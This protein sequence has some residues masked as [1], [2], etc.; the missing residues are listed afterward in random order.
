MPT[1]GSGRYDDLLDPGVC[2]VHLML[3]TGCNFRCV[4]CEQQRRSPQRMSPDVLDDAIRRLVSSR[5]DRPTLTFFGGEPLLAAPLIRRALNRV[6]EW[7]P[8]RMKPD[9][10]IVTNGSRLDEEM[11]GLLVGRDVFISLSFDGVRPAQDDRKP[12]SFESLDELLIRL[13][14]DHPEHF[15]NRVAVMATLTS[16]NVPFLAASFR[17]FLSRSVRDVRVVPVLP[18]DAGWS[19]RLALELDRQLAGV[20][21][22][23]VEEFRRSREIPFRQFRHVASKLPTR[24]APACVCGS[25]GLVFVDVDG[26]LAPCSSFAPSTLGEKPAPLRRVLDALG[27]LHVADVNLPAALVAREKHARRLRFLATADRSSDGGA[28]TRCDARSSCFVCP[29]AIACNGGRVPAFHCDVNRLLARHRA[30]FHRRR[31]RLIRRAR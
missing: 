31:D 10:R 22:L 2:T 5:L 3:T 8:R 7:A 6:R 24:R 20:V 17:Y 19:E 28:C 13:R 14:R 11:T 25:R 12:G 26:T 15:R 4:Y 9:I 18:D 21:D 16:R 23:S 29:E 27:G 30:A 1:P